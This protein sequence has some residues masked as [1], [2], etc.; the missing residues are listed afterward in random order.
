MSLPRFGRRT[1][2]QVGK[3]VAKANLGAFHLASSTRGGVGVAKLLDRP[4]DDLDFVRGCNEMEIVAHMH[5]HGHLDL[6]G[7]GHS[8]GRLFYVTPLMTPTPPTSDGVAAA[9]LVIQHLV[10]ALACLHRTGVAHRDVRPANIVWDGWTPRLVDF[11]LT[12][13]LPA[14]GNTMGTGP[15]G[16]VPYMAPEVIV[17]RT[18]GPASDLWSLGVT[19]HRLAT[20]RFVHPGVDGR[21]IAGSIQT[22]VST[23]PALSP[24][25][26]P[27]IG[28]VVSA[29]VDDV[30]RRVPDAGQLM[31]ICLRTAVAS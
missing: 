30:A 8:S 2:W 10:P 3:Q 5:D 7:A 18:S 24:A 26:P 23:P 4:G 12:Q 13:L 27:D 31:D 28:A 9:R 19:L 17:G 22:I 20:G 21:D 14:N 11:G 25:L 16:A 6:L 1:R 29:C 15:L